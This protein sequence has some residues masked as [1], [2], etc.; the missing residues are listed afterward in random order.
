[1]CH[2][3]DMCSACHSKP[4]S[5]PTSHRTDQWL[6]KHGDAEGLDMRCALCHTQK[7]CQDCHGLQMPHPENWLLT[8]H[9]CAAPSEPKTCA[10]CHQPDFCQT[11][12][13]DTPPGSHDAADF[14]AKHG[15]DR[16]QEP[17]CALC[18]GRYEKNSRD[19]CLACH[20]GVQMPHP[21]RYAFAHKDVASFDPKG[22]CLACHGLSYCKVC[23]AE[24]PA[25]QQ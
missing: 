20:R 22:T 14:R 1:V 13:R 3:I 11:C 8:Q 21:D 9:G 15:A 25:A 7:F 24:I 2:K 10:K 19:A 5:M 17:L 4:A 6:R 18:H 23:H 16:S 12:H